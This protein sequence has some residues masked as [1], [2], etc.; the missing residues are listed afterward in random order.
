MVTTYHLRKHPVASGFLAALL[1]GL[2]HKSRAYDLE[3]LASLY[4][5]YADLLRHDRTYY[6][7]EDAIKARKLSAEMLDLL[8]RPAGR[9]IA[10]WT[11]LRAAALSL[12]VGLLRPL[13]PHA[14]P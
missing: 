9:S 7:A 13:L 4:E 10:E 6:N 5:D 14:R 1:G 11:E 3:L 2:A 12:L 8:G